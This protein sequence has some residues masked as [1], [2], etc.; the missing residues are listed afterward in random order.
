METVF[1]VVALGTPAALCA[2]A[3]LGAHFHKGTDETLLDWQP[4]R[5]A[6][7]EARLQSHEVEQMLSAVNRYRSERG[8]PART[9]DQIARARR[10]FEGHGVVD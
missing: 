5:S 8:L 9:I 6:E 3:L 2:V 10:D 7:T 1:L 4:T